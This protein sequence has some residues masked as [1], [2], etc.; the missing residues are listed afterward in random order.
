MLGCYKIQTLSAHTQNSL[1]LCK[2]PLPGGNPVISR[3]NTQTNI[4]MLIVNNL[5][6]YKIKFVGLLSSFVVFFGQ[7]DNFV[8]KMYGVPS[9]EHP[10]HLHS[11]TVTISL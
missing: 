9:L 4:I 7:N 2:L 5:C 10:L 1:D 6:Q 8:F 3:F 11:S